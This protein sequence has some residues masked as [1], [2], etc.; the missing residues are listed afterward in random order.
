MEK[1]T[2]PLLN[3][4]L[5]LY[6]IQRN[7]WLNRERDYLYKPKGASLIPRFPMGTKSRM[8]WPM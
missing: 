8:S 2:Q 7:G 4:L 1:E 5:F 6:F 3:R